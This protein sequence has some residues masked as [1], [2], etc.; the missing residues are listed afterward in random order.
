VLELLK[1][2]NVGLQSMVPKR[3]SL[4]DIFLRETAKSQHRAE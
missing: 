3:E 1:K 4:E 2:E